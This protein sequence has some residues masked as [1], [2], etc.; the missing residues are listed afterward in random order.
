MYKYGLP[1]VKSAKKNGGTKPLLKK[2]SVRLDRYDASI[3]F[4]T[5]TATVKLRNK[6]FK[7]KLLHRRSY[8]DKFRSRKWYEVV[9]RWLPGAQVEVI[10][11]FRFEHLAKTMKR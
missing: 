1:L 6:T 3:D 5:W 2:L 4:N 8:L 10:I 11:P 7:L 9:V